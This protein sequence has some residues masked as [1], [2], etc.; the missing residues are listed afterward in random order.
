MQK[1]GGWARY[2][3]SGAGL[4]LGGWMCVCGGGGFRGGGVEVGVRGGIS[5]STEA[6]QKGTVH[7]SVP[8]ILI[9]KRVIK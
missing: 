9:N 1:L 2:G 8:Q 4:S 7:R 5:L 3:V 6:K